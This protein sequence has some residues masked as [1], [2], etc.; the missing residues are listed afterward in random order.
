V[1][2]NPP[3]LG[4][5][6][7]S[8]TAKIAVMGSEGRP[9]L[10]EYRR[11]FAE[12]ARCV[13]ALLDLVADRFPAETFRVAVCGSGGRPIAADLGVDFVQEVVANSI[14]VKHLH[15]AARTA[16]ELGGQ[17]AKI[18]FF[19]FDPDTSIGNIENR[20]QM[21]IMNAREIEKLSVQGGGQDV[22]VSA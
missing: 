11:H 15:P 16:I 13:G 19:H 12:Q 3:L 10:S 20:L 8:T 14:A 6:V 5:D 1:S 4:I 22:S 17:D 7:G 18:I 9:L 2:A 21:L